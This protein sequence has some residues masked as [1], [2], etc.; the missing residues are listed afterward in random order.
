MKKNI[1]IVILAI[2]TVSSL[3]FAYMQGDRVEEQNA[4]IEACMLRAEAS[5]REAMRQREIAEEQR[6]AAQAQ[7]AI[8]AA[9]RK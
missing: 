5:E 7:A 9:E 2:T 3:A 1:L 8:M 4:E 6:R